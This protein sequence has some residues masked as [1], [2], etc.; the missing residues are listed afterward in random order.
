MQGEFEL[1]EKMKRQGVHYSTYQDM[2]RWGW[3]TPAGEPLEWH[4][5]QPDP[6]REA[7][8]FRPKAQAA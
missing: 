3:V 7:K 8:R 6:D 5:W 1:P 2:L 4:C